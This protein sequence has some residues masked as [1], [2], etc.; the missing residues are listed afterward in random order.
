MA[1]ENDTGV[2]DETK[3]ELKRLIRNRASIKQK[4]TIL[5]KYINTIKTSLPER[6]PAL[7]DVELRFK[8]GS[9]LL[10]EFDKVQSMIESICDEKDLD[11]HYRERE[12]FFKKSFTSPRII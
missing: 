10:Q 5:E 8:D 11:S 12:R 4:L 1:S 3:K 2:S 9:L 6:K 7:N